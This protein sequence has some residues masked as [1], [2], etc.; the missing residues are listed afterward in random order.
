MVTIS[1]KSGGLQYM[2]LLLPNLKKLL[3]LFD[4]FYS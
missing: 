2:N 3:K 1:T 4:H